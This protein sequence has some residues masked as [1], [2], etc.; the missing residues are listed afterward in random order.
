MLFILGM[1]LLVF[2]VFQYILH[3]TIQYFA[4]I[5]DC[6]GGDPLAVPHSMYGFRVYLMFFDQSVG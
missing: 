1:V 2:Y 5:I 4:K 6:G 3:F